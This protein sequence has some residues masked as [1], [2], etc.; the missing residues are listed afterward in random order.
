MKSL[1][2]ILLVVA[3]TI[4]GDRFSRDDSKE[5]VIDNAT[6]LMWQDDNDAKTITKTWQEAIRYCE[7]LTLGGYNDWNLTNINQLKSIVDTNR[8]DPAIDPTFQNVVSNVY[9]SS[10]TGASGTSYAWDVVF[11]GGNDAWGNKTHRYYV[12]CVR[13]MNNEQ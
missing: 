6:N 10:T 8:Y 9:W 11:G 13:D 3:F 5:V 4:A 7:N 12:R 1:L 2:S